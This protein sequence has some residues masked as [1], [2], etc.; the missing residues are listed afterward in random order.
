MSAE[1][2][3]DAHFPALQF[4]FIW[5]IDFPQFHGMV[6]AHSGELQNFPK[7]AKPA[8]SGFLRLIPCGTDRPTSHD[9][10]DEPQM[11]FACRGSDVILRDYCSSKM[12]SISTCSRSS[13]GEDNLD[14]ARFQTAEAHLPLCSL[15]TV[16]WDKPQMRLEI[17]GIEHWPRIV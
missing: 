11:S 4:D 14:A 9:G 12:I 7:P 16:E 3:I 5:L 10:E 13:Y 6:W 15:I 1:Q 17:D 2:M 8:K